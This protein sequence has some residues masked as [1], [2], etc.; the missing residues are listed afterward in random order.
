[1]VRSVSNSNGIKQTN[2]ISTLRKGEEICSNI[3]IRNRYNNHKKEEKCLCVV[4]EL[5]EMFTIV[6]YKK[7]ERKTLCSND[8]F[9]SC[10]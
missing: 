1:M 3:E 6:P 9:C 7:F 8:I 10:I 5:R 4:K 2:N